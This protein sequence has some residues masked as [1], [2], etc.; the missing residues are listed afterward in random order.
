MRNIKFRVWN[1]CE[2]KMIYSSDFNMFYEF[3]EQSCLDEDKAMRFTEVWDKN[4][5]EIWEGDKVNYKGIVGYVQYIAGMFVLDYDDQTD[6]GPIGFLQTNDMEVI[7]NVYD[8][9]TKI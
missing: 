8:K 2:K 6:S 3:F 4:H 7:G 9:C 5:K 1:E